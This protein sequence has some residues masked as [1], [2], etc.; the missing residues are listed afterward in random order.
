MKTYIKAIEELA[1]EL[2]EQ[3]EKTIDIANKLNV[4]YEKGTKEEREEVQSFCSSQNEKIQELMS[5]LDS[6]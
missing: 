2:I 1:E 6:L 4:T 5:E 3:L